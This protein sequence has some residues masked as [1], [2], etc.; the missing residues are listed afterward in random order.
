[1]TPVIC[2]NDLKSVIDKVQEYLNKDRMIK[3]IRLVEQT[4][5]QAVL[6]IDDKPIED[7]KA[8]AWWEGFQSALSM[9]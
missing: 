4:E 1:M 8:L 9:T 7:A 5:D 2:K 6:L 3:G